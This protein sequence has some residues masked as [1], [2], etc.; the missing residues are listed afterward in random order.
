MALHS[1]GN[2]D[3]LIDIC[4]PFLRSELVIT[5]V[6]NHSTHHQHAAAGTRK[7]ILSTEICGLECIKHR[8]DGLASLYRVPIYKILQGLK[9]HL[10]SDSAHLRI[11]TE[12][13]VL[14]RSIFLWR[15]RHSRLTELTQNLL[16]RLCLHLDL[17]GR[18]LLRPD[19]DP[20]M[21]LWRK[22]HAHTVHFHPN[23]LLLI[24][25]LSQCGN[26]DN[27]CNCKQE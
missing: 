9:L 8:R 19:K 22:R 24:T 1:S 25:L 4:L 14:L 11:I 5:P 13:P 27:H 15:T 21:L 26:T 23:R 18:N 17:Q 3:E 7:I 20:R 12:S 2:P 16:A 10:G 6:V